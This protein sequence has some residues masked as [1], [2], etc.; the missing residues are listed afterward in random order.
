MPCIHTWEIPMSA[1]KRVT[2]VCRKCGE[3]RIM[4]NAKVSAPPGPKT[5]TIG[6][7]VDNQNLRGYDAPTKRH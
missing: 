1:N 4:R 2:G 6:D 3:Q 5:K 7:W